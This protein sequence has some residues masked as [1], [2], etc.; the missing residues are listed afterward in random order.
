MNQPPRRKARA[1]PKPQEFLAVPKNIRGK[2]KST[3]LRERRQHDIRKATERAKTDPA[4]YVENGM[5]VH[6]VALAMGNIVKR[7]LRGAAEPSYFEKKNLPYM[8]IYPSVQALALVLGMD[9]AFT[10][11][12]G[13]V[14]W[15]PTRSEM[16]SIPS[17]IISEQQWLQYLKTHFQRHREKH[18]VVSQTEASRHA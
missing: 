16:Y 17:C 7:Y 12:Y 8:K 13:W 5:G 1:A 4:I 15:T 6:A 14:L 9:I 10:T 3:L 18:P 11:E 2:S